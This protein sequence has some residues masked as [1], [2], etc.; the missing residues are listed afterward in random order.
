MKALGYYYSISNHLACFDACF[1]SCNQN[2][3]YV[4]V[5]YKTA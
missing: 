4:N 2:V 5:D 1:E 3:A